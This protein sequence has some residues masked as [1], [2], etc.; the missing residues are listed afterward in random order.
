MW[1]CWIN[2]ASSWTLTHI[3][4]LNNIFFSITRRNS[5][6]L[7]CQDD[8]FIPCGWD[9]WSI[10]DLRWNIFVNATC[11]LLC[12]AAT[13]YPGWS[14]WF[15]QSEYWSD[16]RLLYLDIP[17]APEENCGF[18][19]SSIFVGKCLLV[20]SLYIHL[21]MHIDWIRSQVWQIISNFHLR[22]TKL[23]QFPH[24]L[25]SSS[26]STPVWPEVCISPQ[27]E[28]LPISAPGWCAG[29]PPP[30]GA[31]HFTLA[32]LPPLGSAE[33]LQQIVR[34][35]G[36]SWCWNNSLSIYPLLFSLCRSQIWQLTV[37]L[38]LSLCCTTSNLKEPIHANLME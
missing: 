6:V 33:C 19:H 26:F 7:T 20:E 23:T 35:R 22:N 14:Y 9:V 2:S 37:L 11:T 15:H 30:A 5:L 1:S 3:F 27:G 17:G 16:T 28:F 12:G 29:P 31:A 18:T 8:P 38:L 34:A 32:L 36:F 13:W 24:H 21:A 25:R 4:Y 10:K